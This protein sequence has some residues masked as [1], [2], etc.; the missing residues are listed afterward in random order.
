MHVTEWLKYI[1]K[2]AKENVLKFLVGNKSD[3]EDNRAISQTEANN[4]AEEHNLPYIETSA[5]EGFNIDELFEE[6]LK[7]Y[8][9][10]LTFQKE[11]KNIKLNQVNNNENGC[12]N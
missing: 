2:Y 8:L 4:F 11:E 3:L 10:G 5:K 1:E 7:K 6:T 9:K 12:C